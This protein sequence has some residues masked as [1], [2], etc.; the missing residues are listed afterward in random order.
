VKKILV[1][2]FSSIGDIVLT[3]PI[4]RCLKS[5]LGEVEV[6]YLTKKQF[7]PVVRNNPYIDK[8]Y[9]IENYVKELVK[10]LRAEGYDYIVDLHKN[11]RSNVVKR[12]LRTESFTFNKLNMEKWLAVNLKMK[13]LPEIHIVDRYFEAVEDLGVKNDYKGLDYFIG[14]GEGYDKANLPDHFHTGFIAF[15]IGG[16]HATKRLPSNKIIS[17]IK[18]LEKPVVLI[19][20]PEDAGKAKLIKGAIG[21]KVFNACGEMNISQSSSLIEQADLVISHDTG[22]MHIAAAFNKNIISIWGNTIPEFGMFPYMP[23]SDSMNEI[24]EVLDLPCRPCSKIGFKKCP[25]G[26]FK[27]M[28]D[29]DEDRVAKLANE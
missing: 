22:L 3:T 20:G 27:C 26:H 16:A 29:I 11:V 6:H 13:K 12:R 2:R 19:G 9:V 4:V 24:M 28:N 14:E 23:H 7:E 10:E 8:V 21:E 25:R 1:I 5:Q 18:K 15:V 17:I